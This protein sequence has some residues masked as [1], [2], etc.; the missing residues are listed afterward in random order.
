MKTLTESRRVQLLLA[1]LLAALL[2]LSCSESKSPSEVEDPTYDR[3]TPDNLLEM[4]AASYKDKNLDDYSECLDDDFLFIFTPD[5]AEGLGLPPDEAWWG[6]TDDLSSTQTMFGSAHVTDI[7]F[8]YEAVGSWEAYTEVRADTIFSGWFRRLDPLIEIT[9]VVEEE[10]PIKKLRVDESWL[11]VV[12]VPD[13][14]PDGLYTILSITEEKKQ[15]FQG[16]VVSQSAATEPSTWGGI[17]S[18]WR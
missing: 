8:T 13:R 14:Y 5:V 9:T 16:P 17:K 1:F 12:V 10:D 4:L 7:V 11:D 18:L 15:Q 6:K 3:T 2:V